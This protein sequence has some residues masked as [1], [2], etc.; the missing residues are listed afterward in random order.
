MISAMNCYFI[1]PFNAAKCTNRAAALGHILVVLWKTC[2]KNTP[3]FTFALYI[4]LFPFINTLH[5]TSH[6]FNPLIQQ[7]THTTARQIQQY[8]L[9]ITQPAPP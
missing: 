5:V 9:A 1:T 6:I 8:L 4:N 2:K 7:L 3:P